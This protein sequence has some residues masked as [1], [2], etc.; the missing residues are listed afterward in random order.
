MIHTELQGEVTEWNQREVIAFGG[1]E[2]C[3]I[4]YVWGEHLLLLKHFPRINESLSSYI[5]HPPLSN[6]TV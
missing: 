3:Y 4:F 1:P 2:K 6:S 5:S